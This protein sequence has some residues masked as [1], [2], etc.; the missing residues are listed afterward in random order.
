MVSYLGRRVLWMVVLLVLTSFVTFV[1]FYLLPTGDP[2]VLRAGRGASPQL[3][4]AIRHQLALDRPFYVEYA[5][6]MDRLAF[7]FD[8]G[9]SY[10]NLTPVRSLLFNRFPAT[11]GL[12]LGAVVIWLAIGV[13]IGLLAGIRRGTLWDRGAMSGALVA[14][15]APVYWLGLVSLYLFSKGIG[16]WPVFDGAGSYPTGGA[17]LFTHP[18]AVAPTLVLPWLVL[19]ASFAA[20]YARFVRANVSEVLGEDFVRTARAKGL[21]ERRVILRHVLRPATAP[22]VTLLGM[23]IGILLGGAILVETVFNIPG[24]GALAVNAI[25]QADLP[26]IQG[27]VLVGAFFIILL[28]LLVDVAYAFL[29]PRVKFS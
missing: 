1:I 11:A 4:A 27:T 8:L 20:I 19:A 10:Q 3:L 15:S 26:T 18:L 16:V 25:H 24:V 23:D 9:T 7:H 12:V 2:A 22:V 21:R 14:I 13:L 29:D 5:R 28:N 17:N 6:Y